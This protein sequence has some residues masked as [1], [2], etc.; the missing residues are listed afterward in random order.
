M[1]QYILR[2]YDGHFELHHKEWFELTTRI[3]DLE[4]HV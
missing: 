4:K 3:A 2:D 1:R